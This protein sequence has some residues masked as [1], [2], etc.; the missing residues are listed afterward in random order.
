MIKFKK[1][2]NREMKANLCHYEQPFQFHSTIYTVR[3]TLLWSRENDSFFVIRFWQ[4][5]TRINHFRV[6]VK[7]KSWLI[8]EIFLKWKMVRLNWPFLGNRILEIRHYL[9]R[10]MRY[11]DIMSRNGKL[12]TMER[13]NQNMQFYHR[14]ELYIYKRIWAVD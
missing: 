3:P 14:F 7:F 13:F 1:R 5:F 12:E 9:R 11:S 2:E 4:S 8:L 6:I 10:N